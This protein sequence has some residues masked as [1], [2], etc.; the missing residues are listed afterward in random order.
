MKHMAKMIQEQADLTAE[1]QTSAEALQAE[2]NALQE[3]Y[4]DADELPDEVDAR[5]GELEEALEAF[6]NRPDIF[7]PA[8]IVHAGSFV[9]IDA[10][11]ALQAQTVRGRR[12]RTRCTCTLRRLIEIVERE[13]LRLQIGVRDL[14]AD[15]VRE[16]PRAAQCALEQVLVAAHH[17]DR[18]TRIERST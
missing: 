9:S 5:L 12:C 3:K 6:E 11:G 2:Y 8:E 4:E 15:A 10:E 18:R 17:T 16:T 7:K 14:G 13:L 1:A